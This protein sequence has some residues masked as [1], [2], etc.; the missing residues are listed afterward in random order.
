MPAATNIF[1]EAEFLLALRD[2]GALETPVETAFDELASLAAAI[3]GT[4]ISLV[5]FI[6]GNHPWFKAW[7]GLVP[8]E[9]S[10]AASFWAHVVSAPGGLLLVSDATRDSRFADSPLVTGAPGIRFYAGLALRTPSGNAIGM[11]GV[12]DLQ[13]RILGSRQEES[14]R[15]VGRQVMAQ[16]ELRRNFNEGALMQARLK[17]SQRIT[18]LGDW[19]YDFA[20]HRLL[21]SDEVYRILGIS[22]KDAPPDAENF[23]RRVHPDDLAFVH[24]EKKAAAEGSRLVNFEHRIIRPDGQVR[25]VHQ[26]TE[27]IFDEQGRPGRESGTIQDITER[28]LSEAALRESEERHRKMLMLSSDAHL[29]HVDGVITFVN[30][31]CCQ[32]MGAAEPTQLL[33]R[34]ALEIVHPDFQDLV[35]IRRPRRQRFDDQA[36]P[37]SEMKFIRLDGTAVEVEV[38]SVVFDFHGHEEVQVIARDITARKQAVTALRESEERFRFVT[39]AVSD[40]IWDWDLSTGALWWNDSFLTTFGFA[41]G[42]VAPSVDFWT[43]RIHPDERGGVIDS[44]RRDIDGGAE[45]WSAEYRFERKDGS[46]AFV[47]DRGY[48][49]HN[50][51][52]KAV[53]M[54]GGMRDLTEQKKM[55]TQYLRAQRMESIGTLAGGIAHDLNNV[56]APIMMSI[57]LLKIDSGDDPRRG[58]ILDIIYL[59]SR[60]GADL[61]RQ[62]LSFARGLDGQRVSLHLRQL[63]DDL[64][65]IIG[66]IFPRNIKIV[67]QV[68]EDLWPVTGDPTQLHQVLLNL[69][70]NARD[71]MPDGGTLGL[72]AANITVDAQSAESGRAAKAG[73]YV[74][75][76]VSDTGVGIPPAMHQRI[77]EPFFTT[78]EVGKGTGIGLATV[79][80]IVKSH[81]GFLNVES[82]VGQGSTFTV[83]LPADPAPIACL[84]PP[85][86]LDLPRGKGELVLVIDD[87]FSIRDITQQTLAAFGYRVLTASDGADAVAIYVKHSQEIALV[88]TDMMMPVMG[89]VATIQALMRLNPSVKIIAASGLSASADTNKAD[90]AKAV[91]AGVK[92]FLPKPYTAQTLV[93]LVRE[94]LDGAPVIG[95]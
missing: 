41:P 23:Y 49:F 39:R 26:I 68:P 43:G 36:I 24:R 14:L 83:C 59:S 73:P 81:R 2:S 18:R 7:H 9:A 63:V 79:H 88:V 25:Y 34:P 5:T 58:K 16:L 13:P 82:E 47:Q 42:E 92:H 32:L 4:P 19:H 50:A 54:V 6:N 76:R 35:R 77:F 11:L 1:R 67:S 86:P 53:R 31:A 3:C 64:E 17:T 70:V 15:V 48:I 28:K 44:V 51:E 75:L 21:W 66:E 90:N 74:S 22:A 65:G 29:V 55:E 20:S 57:E 38:T 12:M 89:G 30:Q 10:L 87:E 85:P 62:L 61:V 91:E 95:A 40:G 93:Q 8:I 46:Y 72:T 27:M 80:T 60:R 94:V 33:G 52:G 78:K 69:A 84:P 37:P 45:S 56:L 71:A